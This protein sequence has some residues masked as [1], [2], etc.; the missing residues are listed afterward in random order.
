MST[1]TYRDRLLRLLLLGAI[2]ISLHVAHVIA[3][4]TDTNV[5]APPDYLTFQP[6]VV[7]GSYIDPVF[8]SPIK[9]LT[10]A[11]NMKRADSGGAMPFVGPEYSTMCPFNQDKSR[12]LLVHFSYFGLYDGEGNFL[13]ELPAIDASAEPRWSRTDPNVFYYRHGN[14]FRSYNVGTDASTTVHTFTEYSS[15]SGMG[16]SDISLDGNH[17][18]LAG[19]NRY[20][21]LYE[22][23][24]DSKGAVLDASGHSFDSLYVTPNNNVTVTWLTNGNGTRF[25]GIELFDRNM[26]F[27]RQLAHAGGHMDVTND[28]NGDEVLL[29]VASGD[30]QPLTRCNAGVV[31]IRL[32]DAAQTCLWTAD[33]S[34]G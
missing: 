27:Q 23:S 17:F 10:N 3:S 25:T 2:P 16:E 29:W 4:T 31:K 12:L 32:S 33:W 34:M 19:D 30:P 22:I 9:R 13:K 6:P 1:E 21:F 7:G 20:I 11:M 14:Q 15:V 26:N 5:Y 24:T 28:L 8:G 18:V